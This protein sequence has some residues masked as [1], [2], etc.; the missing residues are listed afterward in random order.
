MKELRTAGKVIRRLTSVL[1]VL[2]VAGVLAACQKVEADYLFYSV[3]CL[4]FI[5]H[6]Q[7]PIHLPHQSSEFTDPENL[8]TLR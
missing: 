6:C 8:F 2:S 5:I 1:L 7:S 3:S 4:H